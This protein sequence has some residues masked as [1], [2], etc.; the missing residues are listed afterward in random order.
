M[1]IVR[2]KGGLGNQMF[3]YALVEALRAYG[4]EVRCSLGFYKKHPDVMHF[5]LKDI[6]SQ[7]NLNEIEEEKGCL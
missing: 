2:F 6:F 1:D 3:Q 7:V 4:R 5:C